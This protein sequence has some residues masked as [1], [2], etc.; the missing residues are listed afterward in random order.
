MHLTSFLDLTY[1]CIILFY[2]TTDQTLYTL[3]W[4]RHQNVATLAQLGCKGNALSSF[5]SHVNCYDIMYLQQYHAG[6]TVVTH[7][8]SYP[9]VP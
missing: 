6:H 8:V 2:Y 1:L 3:S 5:F 4:S 7:I 9:I